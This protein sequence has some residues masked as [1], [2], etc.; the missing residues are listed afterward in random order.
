MAY[1][2][3][4]PN[5][6]VKCPRSVLEQ[7]VQAQCEC[8]MSKAKCE[9]SAPSAKSQE[10]EIKKESAPNLTLVRRLATRGFGNNRVPAILH[11]GGRGNAINL[12][13]RSTRQ[14]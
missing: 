14:H 11:I 5:A 6:N 8:T 7:N 13:L 4:K 9:M 2:L 1:K 10:I 3:N 12:K